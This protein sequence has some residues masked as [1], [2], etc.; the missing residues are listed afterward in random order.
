MPRC[1]DFIAIQFKFFENS[2]YAL[3]DHLPQPNPSRL[4]NR[5]HRCILMPP[6]STIQWS[7]HAAHQN[8]ISSTTLAAS[9]HTRLSPSHH[10]NKMTTFSTPSSQA[11]KSAVI[12]PRVIDAGPQIP[13]LRSV[14]PSTLP[15]PSIFS[16][17]KPMTMSAALVARSDEDLAE[18]CNGSNGR[19]PKQGGKNRAAP[20]GILEISSDLRGNLVW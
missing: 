19:I 17:E 9:L 4:N 11:E 16:T 20:M 8:S 6:S 15:A 12:S 13:S 10:Q 3:R 1:C 5:R 7:I 18:E 2:E 14:N